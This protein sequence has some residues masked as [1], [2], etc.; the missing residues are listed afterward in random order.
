MT[1]RVALVGLGY[2][3]PNLARNLARLDGT[4]LHA[5]CDLNSERLAYFG[6][7]YP[8]A[9]TTSDYSTI[10]ANSDIDA[11]VVATP[12]LLILNWPNP[13]YRQ[14]SLS[15]SR[16][17]WPKPALIVENSLPWQKSGG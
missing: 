17:L 1:I 5:L 2:W 15:W 9:Y 11:V 8:Q 6:H 4:E 13:L 14:A 12:P 7:Q 16:S 3:G 10:L